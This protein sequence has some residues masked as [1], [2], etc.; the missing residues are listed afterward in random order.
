MYLKKYSIASFILMA[1]VGAFVFSF[2]TQQSININVFGL[3]LPTLSIA[4]WVVAP[5]AILYLASLFH[6]LYYSIK[7][8]FRKKREQRDYEKLLDAIVDAY[9]LKENRQN[10][11]KSEN[12]KT[13][14]TL[15]DNSRVVAT[16]ANLKIE[17]KKIADVLDVIENIKNG[18]VVEL[19]KYSLPINN[20][21]YRQNELNRYKS[22]Q[23]DADTILSHTNRYD[24]LLCREVYVD[25]V[26][27]A[28]LNS[29]LKYSDFMSKDALFNIL[30][31]INAS[32]DTLVID[33]ETLFGLFKKVELSLEEYIKASKVVAKSMLPD[34]RMKLFEMLSNEV[35]YAMN[36]YLYTLF[37]LGMVSMAKEILNNTPD[38][39][40]TKFKIFATLK[41]YNKHYNIELFV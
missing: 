11:Y 28:P 16:K 17:D 24:E 1:L 19:K 33:N 10:I 15:V 18:V 5:M 27:K 38:G 35:E 3:E 21:F 4:I 14:G 22:N 6:M 26:K 7:D 29:I 25:F 34:Q 30:P 39:E 36:A 8:S 32:S 41:D 23:I 40:F 31:R 9:L 13:L 20:S 37:D 12:F 2:I